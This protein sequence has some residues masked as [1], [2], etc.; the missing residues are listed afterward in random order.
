MKLNLGFS[1]IYN[2]KI[3]RFQNM[4]DTVLLKEMCERSL[5]F[6][7]LIAVLW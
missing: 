1:F 4:Y 3:P 2:L 6:N 5:K 7:R